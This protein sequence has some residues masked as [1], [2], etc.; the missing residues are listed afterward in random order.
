MK[1]LAAV[2]PAVLLASVCRGEERTKTGWDRAAAAKYLDGRA[3][4]WFAWDG[5]DRGQGEHKSSCVS[6]HT[7]LPYALARPALRKLTLGTLPN[8]FESRVLEQTKKRVANW[9]RLDSPEFRLMYD[10]S[11]DKKKEARGTEA[12][13]NALILARH[14]RAEGKESPSDITR[15]AF[16]HLW[17]TQVRQGEMAGSWNWLNF[18]LEPW[19]AGAGRYFGA[20]LA[21]GAVGTAPGLYKPGTDTELDARVESLRSYLR[22]NLPKQNLHNRA[23]AL[24]A[25]ALLPKVLT[26]DERKQIVSDLR[27]K[28]QAAGGWRLADLGGYRRGDG[29]AQDAAGDGYAT[30]LV[31]YV[32]RTAGVPRNDPQMA[33]GLAWLEANQAATGEWRGSSVNRKRDPA[34]HTGKFMTDAATA[35]ATLAL[36]VP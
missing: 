2:L 7:L 30:G 13:L 12:V 32:L 33:K 11:E 34:T 20:V 19:E 8:K 18:G 9:E 24:W 15:K 35:Y 16:A 28:Q 5:A 10:F 23:W 26:D 27:A 6:C 36:G 22:S 14:D 3:A 31:L 25:A 21:A 1:W 29:A 17:A 4:T